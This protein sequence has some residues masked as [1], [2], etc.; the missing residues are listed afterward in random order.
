MNIVY[1]HYLLHQ[2]SQSRAL[3]AA[4]LAGGRG[5]AGQPREEPCGRAKPRADFLFGGRHP[6][7]HKSCG[8][9]IVSLRIFLANRFA[10]SDSCP[11]KKLL[12]D[13]IN[14]DLWG[15]EAGSDPAS[16]L[17]ADRVAVWLC[18]LGTF[19]ATRLLLFPDGV[20][21]TK[22]VFTRQYL[23]RYV[24]EMVVNKHIPTRNR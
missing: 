10:F 1:T 21:G 22:C 11:L 6:P 19:F 4:A 17:P 8:C 24:F 18:H 13:N 16:C 12:P 3:W 14:F 5:S 7:S 2:N 23:L 20:S 15:G 9:V